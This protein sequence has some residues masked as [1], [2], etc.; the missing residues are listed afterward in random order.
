MHLHVHSELADVIRLIIA[1]NVEPGLDALKPCIRL[2]G[3]K[4]KYT[5]CQLRL[6]SIIYQHRLISEFW[7]M[8]TGTCFLMIWPS[9]TIHS[10]RGINAPEPTSTHGRSGYCNGLPVTRWKYAATPIVPPSLDL[11]CRSAA[12]SFD[13]F[14]TTR[15]VFETLPV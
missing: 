9:G 7:E 3:S 10:S 2:F 8:L 6:T 12:P 5:L 13:I 4:I 1:Q 14:F 15:G 11:K